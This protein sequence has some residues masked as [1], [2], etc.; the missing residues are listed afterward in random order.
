MRI[1]IM[2]DEAYLR[3]VGSTKPNDILG[4][5]HDEEQRFISNIFHLV[6]MRTH[7]KTVNGCEIW[8]EKMC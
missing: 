1:F 3:H 2:Q 7:Q 6:H 5:K 8:S 4:W